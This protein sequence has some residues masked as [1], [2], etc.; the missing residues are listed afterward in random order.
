MP[1]VLLSRNGRITVQE[2]LDSRSQFG[3]WISCDKRD[4]GVNQ[5]D[6]YSSTFDGP[7][8]VYGALAQAV[9]GK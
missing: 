3:V 6:H 1:G 8:A 7:A 2:S 5:L 4:Q 9:L